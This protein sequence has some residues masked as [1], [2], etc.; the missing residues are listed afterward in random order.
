MSSI[1]MST[2]RTL[3]RA[4]IAFL[5]AAS[6]AGWSGCGWIK[7]TALDMTSGVLLEGSKAINEEPDFEMVRMSMPGNLKTVEVML[8]ANPGNLKLLYMLAQGFD[9]YTYLVLEDDIDLADAAGDSQKVQ[10]LKKRASALYARG[11]N[12]AAALLRTRD[13]PSGEMRRI[14]ETGTLDQVRAALGKMVKA[15]VP[16][17]FWYTFG[18]VGQ[19]NLDQSNPAR[20]AEL[21]RIEILIG[22][23]VELDPTY[24]N[25]LPLIISGSVYSS[26]GT[27]FGGDLPRGNAFFEKGVQASGGR[28]LLSKFV[29]ARYYALQ[30]QDKALFC[31]LLQEVIDAPS[32]LLPEQQM[33]NNVSQR[34]AS[35][36]IERASSLFE[37]GQG[38]ATLAPGKGE[39]E[40]ADDGL[41]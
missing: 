38:C 31:R 16:G 40:E 7:N 10:E 29:W 30:A 37:D 13:T 33:M 41:L 25:G 12:Y 20:I 21:P 34:W 15:D 39:S 32:D 23:I 6:V 22:R 35:R 24:Y 17:L 14:I 3:P 9:A 19:I 5:A 11:Q 2:F 26:R 1:P 36:W 28:F 18:W 8:A 4:G 27:M